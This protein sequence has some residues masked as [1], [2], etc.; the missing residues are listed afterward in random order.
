MG[1]VDVVDQTEE[2]EA[3]GTEKVRAVSTTPTQ[4]LPQLQSPPLHQQHQHQ[5]CRLQPLPRH[6]KCQPWLHPHKLPLHLHPS[7]LHKL[8]SQ[9][10]VTSAI[11]R[12]TS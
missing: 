11:P 4:Q 5:L 10:D 1:K 7:R 9:S 6:R 8:L 2:V 12:N 3:K